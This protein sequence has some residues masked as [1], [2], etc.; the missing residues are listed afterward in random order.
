VLVLNPPWGFAE[1]MKAALPALARILS[2]DTGT[3][4]V[5]WLVPE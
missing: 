5:D 1:Q 4:T 3:A 2:P